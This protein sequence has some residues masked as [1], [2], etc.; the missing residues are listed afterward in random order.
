MSLSPRS[1]LI[2]SLVLAGVGLVLF[3]G[4]L[5]RVWF[6]A[7][8]VPYD[9]IGTALFIAA[10]WFFVDAVHRVP[11]DDAVASIA[12]GEWQSWIGVVFCSAL[13]WSMWIA[14]P[15]FAEHLPLHQNPDASRAGRGVG[16]LIAA[17]AVLGYVLAQR[18]SIASDERDHRIEQLSGQW[19]RVATTFAVISVAVLLGFSPTERLQALSYPWIS[20]LLIVALVFGAWVDHAAAAVLYWRDRRAAE[21]T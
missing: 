14:A 20:Q 15:H 7:L 3:F 19:G 4:N 18:W 21:A 5:Y 13:L 16:T 6:R 12:P 17:W 10:V 1:Q 2:A 8:D 9:F 11:A